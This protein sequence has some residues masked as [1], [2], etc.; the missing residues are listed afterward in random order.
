M[1]SKPPMA[2]S[3][4]GFSIS[5][6]RLEEQLGKGGMGMVYRAHDERLDRKVAIKLLPDQVAGD[7]EQRARL[8]AE[9]R[10]ASALNHPG[11][12]TIHEVGED[13]EKLFIVMEL[14]TGETLR[15]TLARGAME[16]KPLVRLGSQIA[17]VLAVAH[18]QGVVHGDVKPENIMVQPDGRAKLLDFGIARRTLT[19]TLTLSRVGLASVSSSGSIAGTIAYMAPE[20]LRGEPSDA[21]ADL[22]SLGVVLYELAAGRRPFPG[23]T[24][25]AIVD[26]ILNE[27]PASLTGGAP[28]ELA[29]IVY[30]LLEKRP[31]SRYPSA[32][33]A[34]MDL[35]N[36]AR[37]LDLGMLPAAV[38]G[39]HVLA[40]L[41]FKLLTPNPEDD[42]LSVALADAVIHQ[43]SAG[44]HWLVRPTNTV[45]K[46]ARQPVDVQ[47]AARELNVQIMVEGT[48]QK[49]GQRLRVHVRAWDVANSATLLSTK[50]D[51]EMAELFALQDKIS[52][53]VAAALGARP[54]A[55]PVASERPTNNVLA[56]ELFLRAAERISRLNRW[57]TRTAIEMLENAT[58][59]D[60]RFADAW[61]RLAEACLQMAVTFEPGPR[62]FRRAEVAIRRA[63]AIDPGNAEAQSARGQVLW[64]PVKGFQN[65]AALH[66]LGA[67]LRLNPGCHQARIW[68]CLVFLHL[69]LLKEA[70]EGLLEALATNPDDARTLVF[71]GQVALYAGNYNEADEYHERALAIDP[72]NI[73][74]NLFFPIVGLSSNRL[75]RAQEQLRAAFQ[76]L[77]S[78]A[79]TEERGSADL[80]QAR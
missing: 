18:G 71:I 77:P 60:P 72:A 17:E 80:G 78:E 64:T 37:D 66:A 29:R 59:L 50:H 69:G 13:S 63:L 11:I 62:W 79:D 35:I 8:M 44:G 1:I 54:A 53:E 24:A 51:S 56:Y 33:E 16:V 49:I 68:Q 32:R 73:W 40:V 12:V 42:Y 10:A 27:A 28:V 21:R 6:Y 61:A 57:D 23:P 67:A 45:M 52:D 41:P 4:P 15:A 55:A 7:A 76:V 26:Q 39:K 5:H 9:A 22:F 34:Q 14:V 20:A 70:R 3:E 43:L 58:E 25:T 2:V 75:E 36:L 38:A 74:A 31:E 30:K 48:I 46:Y 65:R 47:D 19:E